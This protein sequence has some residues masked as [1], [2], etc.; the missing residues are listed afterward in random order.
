MD[1]KG[2]WYCSGILLGRAKPVDDKGKPAHDEPL[3]FIFWKVK[4]EQQPSARGA[5]T[6]P[7]E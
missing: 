1:S 3:P 5:T 4:G 6:R 7:K 2:S